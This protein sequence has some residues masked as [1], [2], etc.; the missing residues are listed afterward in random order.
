MDMPV[1][2]SANDA[3]IGIQTSQKHAREQPCATAQGAG[4]GGT[5]RSRGTVHDAFLSDFWWTN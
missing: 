2:L 5:G 1:M 3:E 4:R